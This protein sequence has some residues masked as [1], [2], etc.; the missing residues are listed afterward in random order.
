MFKTTYY[1]VVDW[2]SFSAL[3]LLVEWL[4][5]H[6]VACKNLR[7]LIVHFFDNVGWGRGRTLCL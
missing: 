7:P 1:C 4:S 6:P 2:Y 5:T 3:T